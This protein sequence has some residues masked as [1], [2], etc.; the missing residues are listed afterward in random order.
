MR[1]FLLASWKSSNTL[2]GQ[3]TQNLNPCWAENRLKMWFYLKFTPQLF[4]SS[5]SAINKRI[6]NDLIVWSLWVLSLC[7]FCYCVTIFK[8]HP[9]HQ[10]CQPTPV[11]PLCNKTLKT[12][13]R[14]T[15]QMTVQSAQPLNSSM[16]TLMISWNWRQ[17]V[18]LVSL[19]EFL[20]GSNFCLLLC[21][22][23]VLS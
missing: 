6:L 15:T 21:W 20:C 12:Q 17:R 3:V 9:W 5:T 18:S 11:S 10:C 8:R 13:L 14:Q 23:L 22:L 2:I 4:V 19:R 7:L 1:W 16:R